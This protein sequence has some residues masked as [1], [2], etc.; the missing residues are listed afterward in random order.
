ML[1]TLARKEFEPLELRISTGEALLAIRKILVRI[2][3]SFHNKNGYIH[4][5][6]SE[7]NPYFCNYLLRAYENLVGIVNVS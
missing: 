4:W 5:R 1:V 6:L 3:G 7:K 2:R